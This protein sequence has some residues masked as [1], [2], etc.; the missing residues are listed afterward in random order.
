MKAKLKEFAADTRG[1]IAMMTAASVLLIGVGVGAALD[2]S[3]ANSVRLDLQDFADAAALAAAKDREA[4]D[5]R[6]EEIVAKFVATQNAAGYPVEVETLVT[7]E[8]VTV[9]IRSKSETS[10]MKIAGMSEMDVAVGAQAIRAKLQPIHIAVVVDTTES[11]AGDNIDALRAAANAMVDEMDEPGHKMR[12]SLV[13][14]GQ[15]VNVGT[16]AGKPGGRN[17]IDMGNYGDTYQH[18]WTPKITLEEPDCKIVGT[19]TYTDIR[20]GRNFGVKTKDKWECTGGKY[21]DGEEICQM[22]T[23]DWHGCMGSRQGGQG[24]KAAAGGQRIPSANDKYCGSP[25]LP[26]TTDLQS[27]GTAVDALTLKGKTYIPSGLMWGWRTLDPSAPYTEAGSVSGKAPKKAILLMTDGFNT[28]ARGT[29]DDKNSHVHER[30]DDAEDDANKHT[31]K[32]CDKIKKDDIEI[33]VVAYK[34]PGSDGAE[35]VLKTCATSTAHYFSPDS[36]QQLTRDFLEVASML[37][38]TRLAY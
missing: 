25:I 32:V 19:E 13:P 31:E 18:C 26:L 15:Y 37:D 16:D 34:F 23:V 30:T 29:N 9:N 8:T 24:S 11:M 3:Q 22:R 5:A 17:W 35:A 2:H 27:I 4:S 12:M 6:L 20:D 28:R 1:N 21:E 7:D 33:F 10:F 38:N 36:A 14:F